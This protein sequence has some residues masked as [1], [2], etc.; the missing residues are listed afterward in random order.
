MDPQSQFCHNPDCTAR[1]RLGLGNIS[2]HSRKERRYRCSVCGRTFA[3]T[4]DTPLYRLKKSVDLVTLVITLLCHGC[5]VQAIVAAFGLD[6]RTVA[7]WPDRA[8]RHG[9]LFHEHRV[10]RGQVEL[11]HVQADELFVKAVARRLWMAMAMAVPSRPW[12]GGVVGA[13]RDLTLIT[14]VVGL[15]RRAAK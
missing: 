6:E 2:V 11:G 13:R 14:A 4:R 8:G 15:V 10:L 3:A 9:Q 7:D 5:P 1:G 12:G